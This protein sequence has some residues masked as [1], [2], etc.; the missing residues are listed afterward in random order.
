MA[1]RRSWELL[2]GGLAPTF[3][4]VASAACGGDAPQAAATSASSASPSVVAQLGA[5]VTPSSRVFTSEDFKAAGLKAGKSYDVTGLPGAT[6]AALMFFQQKDVELRFF[7][8][9]EVAVSQG[10]PVARE[11]VGP[12]VIL[13]GESLTWDSAIND[14]RAC[15]PGNLGGG[16]DCT[17]QP[18][19]ADFVTYGNF[20][21]FCEGRAQD[22]ALAHCQA[23]LDVV[24]K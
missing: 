5:R 17:R 19:Y 6:A 11:V 23:V 18:K 13:T 24:T 22:T 16:R 3:V 7:P 12:D 1:A 15:Q 8:S 10:V 4:L 9:H 21:M 14:Q 20:I 2:A